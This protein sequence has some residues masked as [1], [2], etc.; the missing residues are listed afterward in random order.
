MLEILTFQINGIQIY[1]DKNEIKISHLSFITSQIVKEP[2]QTT[3]FAEH[4]IKSQ[5]KALL[6]VNSQIH[7]LVTSIYHLFPATL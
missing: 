1:L 3:W 7:L 5:L 2:A 6:L 4:D